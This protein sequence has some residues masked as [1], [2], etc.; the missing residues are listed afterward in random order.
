MI[1]VHGMYNKACEKYEC[2]QAMFGERGKDKIIIMI[3]KKRYSSEQS[4]GD[5]FV[6]A[7]A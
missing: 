5:F 7:F 6:S 3:Q 4:C 1:K 2:F